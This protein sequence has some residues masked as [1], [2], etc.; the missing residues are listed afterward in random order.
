MPQKRSQADSFNSGNVRSI[1][2]HRALSATN[3]KSTKP[4]YGGRSGLLDIDYRATS[5]LGRD[6]RRE[7]GSHLWLGEPHGLRQTPSITHRASTS[8]Q[9]LLSDERPGIDVARQKCENS[10]IRRRI[11]LRNRRIEVTVER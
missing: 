6:G 3:P 5:R 9:L 7:A 1:F 8:S 11:R 2:V 4:G 10:N